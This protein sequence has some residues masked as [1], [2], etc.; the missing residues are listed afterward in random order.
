MKPLSLSDLALA[1][2]VKLDKQTV[3]SILGIPTFVLGEGAFSR[4]AWNNFISSTIMPIAEN[5][6]QE[7]TRKE[8]VAGL[9]INIISAVEW[10][11]SK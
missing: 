3:A 1:D 6:Q 4:D 5:I 8:V 2:F 10:L 7:L 11:L 9:E